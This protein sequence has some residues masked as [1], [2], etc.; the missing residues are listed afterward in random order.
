MRSVAQTVGPSSRL[1]RDSSNRG[2]SRATAPGIARRLLVALAL[3]ALSITANP[4]YTEPYAYVP[5]EG[6]GTISVIDTASDAVV[7]EIR[8]GGKPRGIALN[9]KTRLLYVSDSPSSSLKVIDVANRSVV[10]Q[11][12]LGASHKLCSH[13]IICAICGKP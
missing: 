3:G 7:G 11:I 10:S 4:A 2:A 5:N 1:I 6:S 8:T 13:Y 12:S 9:P